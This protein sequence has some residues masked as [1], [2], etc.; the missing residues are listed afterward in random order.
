MRKRKYL[1][2]NKMRKFFPSNNK[3]MALPFFFSLFISKTV[4][5]AIAM[6]DW[7]NKTT[8]LATALPWACY[9]T[10]WEESHLP[11]FFHLPFFNWP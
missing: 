6:V 5:N 8:N 10:Y 7:F 9:N 1:F 2:A 4:G 3:K 11:F